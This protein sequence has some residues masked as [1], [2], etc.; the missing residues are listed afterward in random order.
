M[1]QEDYITAG[2]CKN[3]ND[4]PSLAAVCAP[5][6]QRQFWVYYA[7]FSFAVGLVYLHDLSPSAESLLYAESYCAIGGLTPFTN[8]PSHETR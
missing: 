3:L 4:A 2:V 7:G 8:H 1:A 5:P 6:T